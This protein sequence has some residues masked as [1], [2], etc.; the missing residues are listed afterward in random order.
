MEA[1]SDGQQSL[2][3]KEFARLMR[4]IRP[5]VELAGKRM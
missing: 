5:Y 1:L 4:S 2:D 3:P